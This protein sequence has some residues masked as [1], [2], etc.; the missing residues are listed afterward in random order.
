M[1]FAPRRGREPSD[2]SSKGGTDRWHR[3]YRVEIVATVA[4]AQLPRSTNSLA[5]PP[6]K[7]SSSLS[8]IADNGFDLC[9]IFSRSAS[10]D[11]PQ[12]DGRRE[13][14]ARERTR[15][16]EGING[17]EICACF[18]LLPSGG[19]VMLPCSARVVGRSSDL[20]A[21]SLS[22]DFYSPSLP[23]PRE[24]VLMT[25]FAPTYRC[26]AVPD[27]HRIPSSTLLKQS[28]PT[29]STRYRKRRV[30]NEQDRCRQCGNLTALAIANAR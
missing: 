28:V 3:V 1:P 18:P 22:A 8:R 9:W 16:S 12:I 4:T 21:F 13:M 23:S 11:P 27:L 19:R 26:G 17:T 29:A 15:I 2:W 20:Q 30:V 6:L 10:I 25:A 5:C 14:P 24:P 7:H